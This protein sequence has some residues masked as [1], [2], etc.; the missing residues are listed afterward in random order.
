LADG[1]YGFTLF[2]SDK[3]QLYATDTVVIAI[4]HLK[5]SEPST[6]AKEMLP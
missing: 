1:L 2:V 4:E 6:K 3:L 5:N